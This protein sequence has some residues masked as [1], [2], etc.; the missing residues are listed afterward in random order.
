M[1]FDASRSPRRAAIRCAARSRAALFARRSPALLLLLAAPMLAQAQVSMTTLDEAYTQSFDTLPASGS[2]GWV[3]NVTL[4]GWFHARTGSGTTIVADNGAGNGGN[5]Y[6]YGSAGSSERALGSIGSGNAA[7]G[8]FFW[9]VRL[10][11]HTGGTITSL[12]VAYTGEQWRNGGATGTAAQQSVAFSYLPGSP[13]VS[14]SLAEFQQAGSAVAAL[15]F[16]SPITTGTAGALDGNQAANRARRTATISGLNIPDGAEIML[17]WSD[18]NHVG[19][20][21]GLAIDDFTVTPH[22]DAAQPGLSV[23][24][25]SLAEGNGGTAL[26]RFAV[27]LSAPAPA[28]GVH[29][30]IAT[31]DGT[32]TA[33][34]DYTAVSLTAQTIPAGSTSYT[35]DVLVNGDTLP[36]A[37]EQFSVNVFNVSGARVQ[38][39]TGIGT[40]LNDDAGVRLSI[41]DVRLNEGNSG[42]TAFRFTVSLSEPAPAGGVAF[43]IATADGTATAGSDYAARSLAGQ[44]IAAGATSYTLDVLVNGDTTPESDETFKVRVSNVSRAIAVKAEGVGTIVN[45]DLATGQ[46]IHDVQG[47]GATSPMVGATVSVEGVVTASFQGSGGLSGFFLQEEDADADADPMTSEGIFVYC[48]ACP[49]AV[50]EGQRVYVNGAVSEYFGATQITAST[51]TSV[52]VTDAG[53]HLSEVTP[54]RIA[55]PII[56]DVDAFYEARE[57][58]LVTYDD[59]LL[60]SEYFQLARFGQ[61]TLFPGERPRQFTEDNAPDAAGYATYLSDLNRRRVILDDG[62]NVENW[63]LTLPEGSQ[64]LYH[65]HANGGFSTGTQGSDFFR[66]GDKVE[67][68]S[69][70]LHWSFAGASGTDAWRIRP[71]QARPATFTVANPRPASAPAVNGAIKAAGVNVLNYFTTIDTTSSS[72]SGPC[73]PSGGMDCRGADSA[74]ELVR[75]RERTSRVLCGLNADVFALVEIENDAAQNAIRDLVSA[76]NARCGGAHPYTLV[77]TGGPIGSDA[78]RPALIYRTGVLATVGSPLVDT[79]AIHNRP[80]LAQTFRVADAANAAFGEKFTVVANH[81]KSKG[82]SGASGADSDAGDGQSCFAARRAQQAS[83]LLAWINGTVIP[84][85]GDSDVLMLGDYNSY[86]KETPISTL[87]AGGYVDL[88]AA[89]GGAREYSY[90]FDG[91]LGHLDYALASASLGSQVSGVGIWHIN[92]DEVPVL[93]YNDEIKDVGEA[94]YEEKPDGSAMS[95]PRVLFEPGSPYRASDHDPVLVGLFGRSSGQGNDVAMTISGTPASAQV[96]SSVTFAINASNSGPD[97]AAPVTWK[98]DLPSG[99]T[100]VSLNADP[101]WTCTQPAV[102]AVGTVECTQPSLASGASQSF[103]LVL[104]VAPSAV[105]GSS[106]VTTVTATAAGDLNP[107]NNTAS[108]TTTVIGVADLAVTISDT[109]DPASVGGDLSYA[110]GL[111]NAGPSTATAV[112]VGDVLPAN[113]RFASLTAPSGWNCTTPAVGATGTVSCL[114]N[115]VASGASAAFTVMVKVDAAAG[116]TTLSNTVTVTAAEQDP[117]TANNS[118]TAATT[119]PVPL[120]GHLTITPATLAFGNQA[121]GT[122]SAPQTATL[123][124]DGN[125]ALNVTALTD[126]AA[127]FTRSGG[128]CGSSLPLTLAAN[129]SC[130][131]GYAFTPSAAGAASQTLTVTANAPGGGTI[132]LSGT[133]TPA[134]QADVAVSIGDDREFVRVGDTLNYTIT[135]SNASGPATAT[136]TVGDALPAQLSAGAWTC[137]P[138]GTA[139]CANGS[140]NVLSDVAVL[141]AG[142]HV[143][144][145]YSAKVQ[146]GN[147]SEVIENSAT[148]T[149]TAGAVDPNPA[150]NTAHDTPADVIVI[151][152]DGF[153]TAA[154]VQALDAS[155]DGTAEATLLLDAA[156]IDRLGIMPVA[157]ARGET[158]E[159]GTAFTVEL[160]RFGTQ[161]VAR[162][163]LAGDGVGE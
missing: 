163:A 110:I 50:A 21:H 72:S 67:H 96:G 128:T 118:A 133:G 68:L 152:R 27:S 45:D 134:Q 150:N 153:D 11:N 161:Y 89:R 32:A 9:G 20:D 138:S 132:V 60:V 112:T 129:A 65:P 136:V 8:D 37:D 162:L 135:V 97:A 61:I 4:P 18:P 123:R 44:S 77:D 30:D 3:N 88:L 91:Q 81:L 59:T 85:A 41:D 22:G 142:T 115:S 17:R 95:P 26:F 146:A 92:A 71:T 124:N 145:V 94:P 106:L 159:A 90:L 75:Q 147:A 127:P 107:A 117:N 82:C 52:V 149:V 24:D 79:N 12:N 119:V 154:T 69:G 49:V 160:A 130:T 155:G 74:A 84:A 51:A 66:G 139:T 40:I 63:S 144:Y 23:S 104:K 35:F 7:A 156:A 46:M 111:N 19:N 120:Q 42:T 43:D 56:G 14:G 13:T 78:I 105:G 10:Q 148:A 62:N 33:P 34:S 15:D 116:G 140:G 137:V 87:S 16:T 126:A 29:F 64:Y 73:G 6:S 5:L 151:H 57:S 55:L 158:A 53:N 103:T 93:D 1:F 143:T 38:R 125:A 86:A 98:S 122:T 108:A 109:P 39:G 48:A 131:L 113:V 2:A 141:P 114:S 76:V 101:N 25:V 28:G 99:M 100:F 36:E 70:V 102:G 121:V 157:V 31:G 83:R 47:N 80:P 54:A 58:M